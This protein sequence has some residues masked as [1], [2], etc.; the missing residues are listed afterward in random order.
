MEQISADWVELRSRPRNVNAL[1]ADE[2]AEIPIIRRQQADSIIAYIAR[3]GEM[4][5]I[6]ELQFVPGI[7]K[8]EAQ[9]L[10]AFL[11]ASPQLP[12][13]ET[14]FFTHHKLQIFQR[15]GYKIPLHTAPP[16]NYKSHETT[17]LGNPLALH[18]RIIYEPNN[19]CRIGYKGSK[20]P[21][22]PF[23]Q[24]FNPAGYGFHS[25]YAE[26]TL[27]RKTV[28]RIAIGDYHLQAGH[29]LTA[30]TSTLAFPTYNP[31]LN[32]RLQT[33]PRGAFTIPNGNLL[34]GATLTLN[35]VKWLRATLASSA[36]KINSTLT[37]LNGRTIIQTHR[38]A[39]PF[40]TLR[41]AQRR[42]S[43]WEFTGIADVSIQHGAFAA[44]ITA[45][46][47]HHQHAFLPKTNLKKGLAPFNQSQY[48]VGVNAVYFSRALTLWTEITH[49]IDQKGS[50]L[51]TTSGLLGGAFSPNE[52][53]AFSLLLYQYAPKNSP[54]YQVNLSPSSNPADRRGQHLQLQCT[55]NK[56]LL[57]FAQY[58]TH[59]AT[60]YGFDFIARPQR[61]DLLVNIT[62]LRESTFSLSA[63]YRQKHK[64]NNKGLLTLEKIKK[65]TDE[66]CIKLRGD[67]L[68]T[69]NSLLSTQY[70]LLPKQQH[71]G[72]AIIQDY[73]QLLPKQGLT[74][75][76]RVGYH[77]LLKT[78]NVIRLYEPSPLYSYSF[79][80]LS[81]EA[82]RTSLL[83]RWHP[84][85]DWNVWLKIAKNFLT[86]RTKSTLAKRDYAQRTSLETTIQ[87]AWTPYWKSLPKR[88]NPRIPNDLDTYDQMS[89]QE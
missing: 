45:L 27:Q 72:W 68:A 17:P 8:R 56:S 7:S 74:L 10:A 81:K 50:F 26:V 79:N 6:H 44:G 11:T 85:K 35:P 71:I 16:T 64:K 24:H 63:S 32:G 21:H 37:E 60:E 9:Y 46:L 39:P 55:P 30:A 20:S 54:L 33:W 76:L 89:F 65:N 13:L 22:E 52:V 75:K 36:Q 2:L 12:N 28:Q 49:Q 57:F 80:N 29:G 5:S 19:W 4:L 41:D 58:R 48:R 31:R 18:T 86:S 73:T 40:A 53:I 67:A 3:Y 62:Y 69:Q 23:F 82:I 43:T 66:H 59:A 51:Q 77:N 34:R 38:V 42:N 25:A 83:I 78:N 87:I 14:H 47:L 61:A 1:T 70:F 15:A 88:S 84:H